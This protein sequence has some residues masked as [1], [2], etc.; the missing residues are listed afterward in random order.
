MK[1]G[2]MNPPT[3][4]RG[5]WEKAR[6]TGRW[7][8]TMTK[9]RIRKTPARTRWQFVTFLGPKRGESVGI[10]DL[11]AVRKNQAAGSAGLKRGDLFEIVL[12]QVKGGSA[13]RPSRD[14][15][16]RMRIAGATY[17][18]KAILLATWRKG[19]QANFFRLECA[20]CDGTEVDWQVLDSLAKVFH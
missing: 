4:W 7:A 5:A 15:I 1:S 2:V 17:N 3:D 13:A 8:V 9:V 12:I 10:F 19:K 16:E 6:Q 20:G 18:A 11:L 14:E